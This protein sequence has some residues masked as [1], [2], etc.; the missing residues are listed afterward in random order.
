MVTSSTMQQAR[1][2]IVGRLREIRLDAGPTK[3]AVAC[4]GS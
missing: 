4:P 1:Q 2:Q 3:C